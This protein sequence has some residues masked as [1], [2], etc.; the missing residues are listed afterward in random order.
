[1]NNPVA[2]PAHP[3]VGPQ[4]GS[5]AATVGATRE[6]KRARPATVVRAVGTALTLILV[7]GCYEPA[8]KWDDRQGR[9]RST[10]EMKQEE[11]DEMRALECRVYRVETGREDCI[12]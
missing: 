6:S 1:M 9:F 3:D 4:T 11:R 5:P 10:G 7:S 8:S 2:E 12:P